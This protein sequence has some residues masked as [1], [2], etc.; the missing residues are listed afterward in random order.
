M[1][2][3]S[4]VGKPVGR[5]E[6]PLKVSGAARYAADINLPGMLWGKSLRSP[7]PHAI[8]RSIDVSEAL[9]VPGVHAIVT[10][11]DVKGILSGR[12][13][14]DMPIIAFD[15]VRFIGERVAVV[16]ADSED[17]CEEA[18]AR[19]KVE[20]EELPAVFDVLEAMKPDAPILHPDYNS[21]VGIAEK[22]TV[23][24]NVVQVRVTTKGDVEAG[25][26][27]ADRIFEET[28]TTP[29]SHQS[30][31]EPHACIVDATGAKT[32]VW[33]TSK[34]RFR[35]RDQ[36]AASLKL[37][38]EDIIVHAVPVGGDFGGKSSPMDV[39]VCYLLSKK[40]G[41]PVK[42]VMEYV[43]EFI[44]G[45]PRHPALVNIKV[46]VKTD[47]SITA[48]QTRVIFNSGGY[49]GS[50]PIFPLGGAE[51]VPGPYRMA[52]TRVENYM[53]YTNN[54]PC[55][56]YRAPGAPQGVFGGE[57]MIDLVARGIGQDPAEY[58]MKQALREGDHS[59][60]GH[61]YKDPRAVE[62]LERAIEKSGYK[63]PKAPGVGRGIALGY[64]HTGGVGESNVIL[65]VEQDGSI[66]DRI[67][68]PDI[69]TG[70]FTISQQ[71]VAEAL[72]LPL[73][74]VRVGPLDTD[75]VKFDTGTGGSTATRTVGV[76]TEAAIEDLKKNLMKAASERQG[77]DAANLSVAGG[78]VTDK[79]SG[80]SATLR[81]L[82]E[83]ALSALSGFGNSV[84]AGAKRSTD[85][86]AFV[87]QVA[88][89]EVDRETGRVK[90]TKFTSV[91]DA[92][93]VLNPIGFEGQVDGGVVQGIGFALTEQ[94][95]I[96]N[97]RPINTTFGDYKIPTM[98]DIPEL[99]KVIIETAI[100]SGPY[101]SKIIG[102]PPIIPT[103]A[104]IAN[105][106]EDAVGV[107][108]TDL[109]ITSEK[110]YQALKAKN[111]KK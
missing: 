85:L 89:V 70:T 98:F 9:K 56:F 26:K 110:V 105:A 100:G 40:S 62:M 18:V 75:A 84:T 101:G 8:I 11:R 95:L 52:N 57:S 69:G 55:G 88:E 32:Q 16:A 50:K 38:T 80:K 41:R 36:V 96:E 30:Y 108:I 13:L 22:T 77:W 99:N 31:L 51:M 49:A 19:I 14:L 43:E 71:M 74:R 72:G 59:P 29:W 109:P 64:W 34:T 23:P 1:A 60:I 15:R 35:L 45:N 104:A 27:E 63:N 67:S 111:G 61:E 76:A 3:L 97:G 81:E 66:L 87:A 102:E 33:A 6:G 24:T 79:S 86:A 106:V 94:M 37:N 93:K 21:Y 65:S 47:G 107:R 91:H 53:V 20:Y 28:Y 82:A 12:R 103:A 83:K 44:A 46:G 10:G 73:D 68:M 17:I 78:K 7:F 42:M 4:T 5:V 39:P 25:F 48:F 92:G 2:A 90:L 54:V 58:R